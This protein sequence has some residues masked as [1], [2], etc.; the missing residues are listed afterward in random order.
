MASL[1]QRRGTA[2]S[3]NENDM[4]AMMV[5]KACELFAVCDVENKGYITKK[6][7]QRLQKEL[8]LNPDQ[9]ENVFDSLDDDQNGQLTLEEFTAGFGKT[10]TLST[11]KKLTIIY[12]LST[13][14]NYYKLRIKVVSLEYPPRYPKGKRNHQGSVFMKPRGQKSNPA[15]TMTG[16]TSYWMRLELPKSWTSKQIF[17]NISLRF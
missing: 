15:W 5:Q 13:R 10:I 1:S 9:L 17:F 11:A 2:I 8:P 6:E 7:M 16:S 3:L 14:V 4:Q 12:T